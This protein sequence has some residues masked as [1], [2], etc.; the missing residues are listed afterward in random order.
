MY[1]EYLI[2]FFFWTANTFTR[3]PLSDIILIGFLPLEKL[4]KLKSKN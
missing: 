4:I 1:A 2:F 3:L